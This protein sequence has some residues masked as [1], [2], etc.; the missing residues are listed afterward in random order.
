MKRE[1]WGWGVCPF[2]KALGV[3]LREKRV[4]PGECVIQEGELKG[5][6]ELGWGVCQ[7]C[8]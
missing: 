7:V 5:G 4:G 8:P 6:D 2:R 1:E 3:S